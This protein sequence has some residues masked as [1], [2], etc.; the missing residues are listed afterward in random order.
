[1]VQRGECLVKIEVVSSLS[2]GGLEAMAVLRGGQVLDGVEGGE[3][4]RGQRFRLI[5]QE[6]GQAI[7]VGMVGGVGAGKRAVGGLEV[8]LESVKEPGEGAP[9]D[10]SEKAGLGEVLQGGGVHR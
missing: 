4:R 9:T 3:Q 8:G 7:E 5:L 1:V 6:A 2:Q 10:F